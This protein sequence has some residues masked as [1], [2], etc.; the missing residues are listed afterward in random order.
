MEI[1]SKSSNFVSLKAASKILNVSAET[2]RNWDRQ[3]KL[4]AIRNPINNYRLYDL[5]NIQALAKESQVNDNSNNY[6]IFSDE[7][8]SFKNAIKSMS[9]AFRDSEGGSL[10][11]RFEEISKLLFCKLYD[12]EF[13]NNKAFS[14]FHKKQP[15]DLVYN[16]ISKLFSDAI[17]LHP[18]VFVNGRS[19]L[20]GDKKAICQVS[21]ILKNY[22][23]RTINNDIK[24]KIYEELIKNTLDKNENQQFFTPRNIV[25]FI[26]ELV[27]PEPHH[28]ICDPACG[29]GGFLISA[30][31]Y[32]KKNNNST[33]LIEFSRNNLTGVEIDSRMVWIAQ[34][35]IIL[36]GGHYESIQYLKA[37]GTLSHQH[38][39]IEKLPNDSF[40]I[41]I[42]NPPFGSDY[43]IVADLNKFQLGIGKK[44]RR[45]GVLFVE[46]CLNIL[47]PGGKLAIVLEESILNNNS[48]ED[49]RKYL[50]DNS[51]IEAIIS[52]PDTAFMPY[53]TVK[54]SIIITKKKKEEIN[55][56]DSILMC[57]IENIGFGPN[58]DSIYSDERNEKGELK[59][60]SDFP[61]ALEIFRQFR[62]TARLDFRSEKYFIT[63]T[64]GREKIERLDTLF[65]HPS[66]QIAQEYL[67]N[68]KYP[69]FRL[70]E[71]VTIINKLIVPQYELA[72]DMVRYIGLANINS[73]DGTYYVTEILGEKIKSAVKMFEPNTIIYSKMRPEL[74]KVIYIPESEEIGFVSS[75]CYVFKTVN[76]ILPEYFALVLRSDLVFGQIIFQVTGLGRPRIGKEELLSVKIPVPPID[77]QR[78]I[79]N[80]FN[81]HESNRNVLLEQSRLFQQQANNILRKSF[82]EIGTTLCL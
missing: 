56:N 24:G 81:L 9:K 22:N 74:R 42:T 67:T 78:E 50:M 72:E 38:Q 5:E 45:R 73:F 25:Q 30:L 19:S 62:R 54:T 13:N 75:E 82:E 34:M 58:G 53:A 66:K 35:N 47:K 18:N 28:K 12:E 63:K 46:K 65:H 48:N 14:S 36:H 37:G 52:L 17:K 69:L 10:L 41:V 57:N 43:D 29:S 70:G 68:T 79:I 77:K 32:I 4:I 2:M 80:I 21:F 55:A 64:E 31:E 16:Q 33:N 7:E 39:A 1:K 40:D 44:S 51:E 59:L 71:L 8:S 6:P 26:I 11:D 20:S 3:G 15:D 49:V 60:L 76:K 23:L 27:S 61:E